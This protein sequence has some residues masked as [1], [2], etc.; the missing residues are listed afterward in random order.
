MNELLVVNCSLPPG[1]ASK[2]QMNCSLCEKRTRVVG[3]AGPHTLLSSSSLPSLLLVVPRGMMSSYRSCSNSSSISMNTR[4]SP[5]RTRSPQPHYAS[6]NDQPNASPRLTHLERAVYHRLYTMNKILQHQVRNGASLEDDILRLVMFPTLNWMKKGA[7]KKKNEKKNINFHSFSI[8]FRDFRIHRCKTR[9]LMKEVLQHWRCV[10]KL[11]HESP[12]DQSPRPSDTRPDS[13]DSTVNFTSLFPRVCPD[14]DDSTSLFCSSW[15]KMEL[16][17]EFLQEDGNSTT[18]TAYVCPNSEN[19]LWD[20]MSSSDMT[21][22]KRD[23]V[24]DFLRRYPNSSSL[25]SPTAERPDELERCSSGGRLKVCG[26]AAD[27]PR[28]KIWFYPRFGFTH[29]SITG[30]KWRGL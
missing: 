18:L 26:A 6:D 21:L 16:I 22:F 23:L 12:D 10:N 8:F 19:W 7:N 14:S 28:L 9:Q 20:S 17:R 25:M 3:A 5:R 1:L 4:G 27:E 11:V 2:W 29:T 15:F 24:E 13:D 30:G